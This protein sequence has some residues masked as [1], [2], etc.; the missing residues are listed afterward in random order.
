MK[1]ILH[2]SDLLNQIGRPL[3]LSCPRCGYSFSDVEIEAIIKREK[4]LHD[5]LSPSCVPLTCKN[6][7]KEMIIAELISI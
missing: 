3:L 2:F 6:C 1:P 7:D 4:E 5:D